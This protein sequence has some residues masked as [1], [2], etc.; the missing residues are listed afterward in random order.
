MHRLRTLLRALVPLLVLAGCTNDPIAPTGDEL[1]ARIEV[2]GAGE[3]VSIDVERFPLGTVGHAAPTD[4][5]EL[6]VEVLEGDAVRWSGHRYVPYFRIAEDFSGSAEIVGELEPVDSTVHYLAIPDDGREMIPLRVSIV[7]PSGDSRVFDEV[8]DLSEDVSRT[9]SGLVIVDDD[10]AGRREGLCV[11]PFNNCNEPEEFC[12]GFVSAC[13][14]EACL[15]EDPWDGEEVELVGGGD[16]SV[17][18]LPLGWDDPDAFE[19]YVTEMVEQ[20]HANNDWYSENEGRVS[21]SL[22]RVAC[23]YTATEPDSDDRSAVLEWVENLDDW[24]RQLPDADKIVAVGAGGS[25][26]GVTYASGRPVALTQCASTSDMADVLAHELGHSIAGLM[27]EYQYDDVDEC[28]SDDDWALTGPN[29]SQLDD[30]SWFCQADD[31]NVYAGQECGGLAG[32]VVGAFGEPASACSNDIARPCETS[33]MR[34]H[35][36]N[37]FDP[38]GEAA[39]TWAVDNGGD[40]LGYDDCDAGCDQSCGDFDVGSCGLNGCFQLCNSCDTGDRCSGAQEV[41]YVCRMECPPGTPTCT[42]TLGFEFCDGETAL[43]TDGGCRDG[44]RLA[45]CE[46]GAIVPGGCVM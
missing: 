6:L 9:S 23:S 32:G 35:I 40:V 14:E 2:S 25:C 27:D 15:P 34:W 39:M 8:L 19:Q 28:D 11:G 24:T 36:G 45:R 33:I 21:F 38:V 44:Y 18:F 12:S 41:G 30:P 17:L 7:G 31:G 4:H 22:W 46:G 5:G 3:L 37:Q 42:S 13:R 16:V 20:L 43:T 26:S 10:I 29:L 1:V